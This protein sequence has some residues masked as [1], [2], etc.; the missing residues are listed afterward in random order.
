LW[1]SPSS[2]FSSLQSHG[3]W[4]SCGSF[5]FMPSTQ[6]FLHSAQPESFWKHFMPKPL[7][8][9]DELQLVPKAA[10]VFSVG[11]A[12]WA[13]TLQLHGLCSSSGS[14][15]STPLLHEL[16]HWAQPRSFSKHFWPGIEQHLLKAQFSYDCEHWPEGASLQLH[17]V[18]NSLGSR[19]SIPGSQVFLH[20]P[21]PGFFSTHFLLLSLQHRLPRQFSPSPAQARGRATTGFRPRTASASFRTILHDQGVRSLFAS[22]AWTPGLQL[23]RHS[24]QPLSFA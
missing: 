23:L 16:L 12:G 11:R 19:R 22:R 2:L 8:H 4:Y 13:R 5:R 3:V 21:Q 24:P 14:P 6:L 9:L 1:C 18:W 7:Q 17:A 20:T 10:H 15:K